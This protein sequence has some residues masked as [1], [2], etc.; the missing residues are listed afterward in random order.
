MSYV[1]FTRK[2]N[3]DTKDYFQNFIRPRQLT[4]LDDLMVKVI[5]HSRQ[6]FN[7]RYIDRTGALTNS[8]TWIPAKYKGNMVVGAVL[9]GGKTK[10]TLSYTQKDVYY[11]DDLG[12][13]RHFDLSPDKYI[14]VN[15]G[16]DIYVDYAVFVER[17]GMNVLV[18]S[19]EHWR[20]RSAKQ[21]AD[22]LKKKNM[23]R[24]YKYKYTGEV[25]DLYGD[26]NDG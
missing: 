14:K 18:G 16:D 9:A 1:R 3:R 5:H 7:Y 24:L 25:V 11:Y 15:V 6:V 8:K 21:L 13:L 23:P 26:L 19:I 4:A 10:A 17:K 12:R 2:Y 22:N 20:K